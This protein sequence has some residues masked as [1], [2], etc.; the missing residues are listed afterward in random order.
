LAAAR[1]RGFKRPDA[2]R[3]SRELAVPVIV[4][5][6]VL[7]GSRLRARRLPHAARTPF[8]VGLLASFASTLGSRRLLV[9]AVQD[10]P[11]VQ[12]AAYRMALAA[13]VLV[14]WRSSSRTVA[15]RT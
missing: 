12:Y 5:A 4:G 2:Q 13:A 7:K 14:R 10:Q 1:I 9:P 3:L 11:L 8:T 15:R 6:T